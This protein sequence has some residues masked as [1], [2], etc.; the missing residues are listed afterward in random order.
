MRI[1]VLSIPQAEQ[2][3]DTL[4]D[5]WFDAD[6][7]LQVRVSSDQSLRDGKPTEAEQALIAL[8]ELVE[9]L[10]CRQRG[11][12][13]EAVTEFDTAFAETIGQANPDAEP[14][15]HPRAPYRREHRFAMLVEHLF[16]HELGITGY[17]E[18]R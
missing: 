3:Y 10:L 5:W 11:I 9:A 1:T 13:A 14:G 4:G 16:A 12:T 15:D 2:R 6:G 7:T 8:H 17:G 18:V